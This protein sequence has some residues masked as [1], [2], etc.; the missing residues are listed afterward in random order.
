MIGNVR[1][2][3]ARQATP[4]A[5]GL[6]RL[7]IALTDGGFEIPDGIQAGR[8]EFAAT[9]AGTMTLSHFGIGKFPDRVTEEDIEAFFAAQGEDTDA[10]SFDDI[11]FVGAADWPQP[12]KPPVTGVIDLQPGRYMAFKPLDDSEPVRFTVEGTFPATVEEP[13]ADLTVTLHEMMIELPET[14][15]TSSPVR[16]KIENT[17]SFHH[18]VA[19]LSV[20]SDFTAEDF[21]TLL[22][23]PEEATPPPGVPDFEYQPVSAIGILSPTAPAGSMSNL[24]RVTISPPACSRSAPATRTR[25]TECMSSS[26]YPDGGDPL[27]S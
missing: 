12:G 15:Y 4:V 23:L 14:A 26:M 5:S 3:Y 11:A 9:N 21:Q 18:E 25:W 10:L 6:P 24:R 7:D 13:A 2:A 22:S 16:W 27:A 19:V 1:S 17:G 8:Y 20:P